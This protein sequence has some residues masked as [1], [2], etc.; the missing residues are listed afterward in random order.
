[1]EYRVS[2]QLVKNV[3]VYQELL[4]SSGM[5]LISDLHLENTFTINC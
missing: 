1:M 4:G 2:I 3:A 5:G